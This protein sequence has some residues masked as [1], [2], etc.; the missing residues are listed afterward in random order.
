MKLNVSSTSGNVFPF[1]LVR[2]MFSVHKAK[3]V[4]FIKNIEL[5]ACK[6]CIY[7][8]NEFEKSNDGLLAR[9]T[10]FGEKDIITNVIKYDYAE[11]CR[12]DE[13]KCGKQAT[14]FEGKV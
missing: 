5:P 12:K 3:G 14:Y 1:L 11:I 8:I 2:R 6:N 10:K 7:Y 4:C 13:Q 9:C